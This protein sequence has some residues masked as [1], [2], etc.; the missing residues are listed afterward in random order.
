M[1]LKGK[2]VL[3]TAAGQGIGRAI[4]EAAVSEGA[5][6]TATDIDAALLRGLDG[7]DCAALDV[8]DTSA[9]DA[10]IATIAP[11]V[12][13]YCAGVVHNGTLLE[14]SATDLHAAQAINVEGAFHAIQA[15]LP[16]M[17]ARKQGSIIA[18]SSV[19][20]SIMGAPG[21]CVYGM[22][23]A[24]L[25]GLMKSVATDYIGTGIRCNCICPGT[26]MSPSLK[27]RLEATGDYEKAKAAFISRQPMGRMAEPDEIAELAV[28]LA[29]D[30]SAYMTGQAVVI[31]GGMSS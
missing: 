1:R 27:Q 6:V 5:Q 28:Y 10:L 22:T 11:D 3:I 24:A 18:I 20:S 4:A 31:D 15:A 2:T 17:V 14:A 9:M 12:L 26:V 16:A 7:A 29:S 8:R 30:A 19:V 25:I 13:I 23:K 21:R